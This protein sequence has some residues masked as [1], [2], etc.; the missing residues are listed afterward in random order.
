MAFLLKNC[1]NSNKVGRGHNLPFGQKRCAED[2]NRAVILALLST[3]AYYT[4]CLCR[5]LVDFD[6]FV[7]RERDNV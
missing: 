4:F 1:P 2:K 6:F 5:Y 7:L 3:T